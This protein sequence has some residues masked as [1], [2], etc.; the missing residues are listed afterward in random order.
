MRLSI[1]LLAAALLGP[2]PLLGQ[3]EITSAD[4]ARRL[5]GDVVLKKMRLLSPEALDAFVTSVGP[6]QDLDLRPL[7]LVPGETVAQRGR[8][9]P[10][11]SVPGADRPAFAAATTAVLSTP[12][13]VEAA[14]FLGVA[15]DGVYSYGVFQRGPLARPPGRDEFLIVYVRDSTDAPLR[16]RALPLTANTT[17]RDTARERWLLNDTHTN[18]LAVTLDG[19]VVGHGWLHTPHGSAPALYVRTTR[20]ENGAFAQ[21][22]TT[23]VEAVT[24][25]GFLTAN[26]ELGPDGLPRSASYTVQAH[27]LAAVP[28]EAG[29][30]GPL[31]DDVGLRIRLVAPSRTGGPL[32]VARVDTAPVDGPFSGRA[33]TPAGAAVT[34]NTIWPARHVYV[35]GRR[36]QDARLEVCLDVAPLV[37]AGHAP[38]LVGVSRP[39]SADAWT[40]HD[41][42]R[43][44]DAVC[45]TTPPTAQLAVAADSTRA[46]LAAPDIR[47]ARGRD[48]PR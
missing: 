21:R 29:T 25:S 13:G 24:K 32:H 47:S 40:P 9:L 23:N 37:A 17:W 45:W 35:G 27:H 34:P 42:R 15:P 33:T 16:T 19:R 31:F 28:V 43:V 36:L 12:N 1:L 6:N 26:I 39:T 10:D 38:H 46:P 41:T 3:P 5:T 4:V 22:T 20:D 7:V 8:Q 18:V 2:L 44:D 30:T 11:R 48:R 14:G